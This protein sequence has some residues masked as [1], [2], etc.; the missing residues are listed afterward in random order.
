MRN[1]LSVF[2]DDAGWRK[3]GSPAWLMAFEANAAMVRQ[4]RDR[5]RNEEVRERIPADYHGVVMITDRTGHYGTEA[6]AA[7]R[8]QKC[9]AHML[10]SISGVVDRIRT[11]RDGSASE[12]FLDRLFNLALSARNQRES[13]PRLIWIRRRRATRCRS[14]PVCRTS[15][16]TAVHMAHMLGPDTVKCQE[17]RH[18]IS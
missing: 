7:V 14:F 6:F 16:R 11:K 15:Q 13:A 9:L 1:A 2:T 17:Y 4:I 8:K 10:Q 3:D 18:A 12:R 5:H